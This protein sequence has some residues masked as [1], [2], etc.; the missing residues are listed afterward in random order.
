M[1]DGNKIII[2]P[3]EGGGFEVSEEAEPITVE[4]IAAGIGSVVV[5]CV[6]VLA[7]CWMMDRVISSVTR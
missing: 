5:T 3:I 6:M 2:T 7:V 4:D 1:L